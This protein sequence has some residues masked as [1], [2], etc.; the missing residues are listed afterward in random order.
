M[1]KT[2]KALTSEQQIQN[3]ID[4][5]GTMKDVVDTDMHMVEALVRFAGI[6]A[7]GRMYKEK[8]IVEALGPIQSLVFMAFSKSFSE[9]FARIRATDEED[10]GEA[11]KTGDYRAVREIMGEMQ[12][13]SF[14]T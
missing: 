2:L 14:D 5:L 10:L 6:V 13:M 3:Q 1:K 12:P 8:I 9:E 7:A 11:I 4:V